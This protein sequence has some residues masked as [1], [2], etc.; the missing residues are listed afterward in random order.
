MK[1]VIFPK[2]IIS[3]LF[4]GNS[5]ASEGY[6]PGGHLKKIS[7]VRQDPTKQKQKQKGEY[8]TLTQLFNLNK[9][10]PPKENEP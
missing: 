8:L 9:E 7:K 6:N 1:F 10:P 5:F 2:I 3:D 4:V